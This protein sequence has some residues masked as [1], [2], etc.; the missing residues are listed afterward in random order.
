MRWDEVKQRLNALEERVTILEGGEVEK[1]KPNKE[2]HKKVTLQLEPQPQIGTTTDPFSGPQVTMPKPAVTTTENVG[3]PTEDP[4]V[5]NPESLESLKDASEFKHKR[6]GKKK[7][8]IAEKEKDI[9]K[10]LEEEANK[11][12]FT[13][14]NFDELVDEKPQDPLDIDPLDKHLNDN[15]LKEKYG[16]RVEEAK[17][18]IVEMD[19]DQKD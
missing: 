3:K 4:T 18:L 8:Q 10:E 16:D 2:K 14:E 6:K 15:A 7:A 19:N 5:I 17:R 13:K 9:V 11:D 12:G 1:P